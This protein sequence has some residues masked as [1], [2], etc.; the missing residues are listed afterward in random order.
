V[1]E[2]AEKP[3]LAYTHER[4]NVLCNVSKIQELLRYSSAVSVLHLKLLELNAFPYIYFEN[5]IKVVYN[6]ERSSQVHLKGRKKKN[7]LG[8]CC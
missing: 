3:S 1:T 7:N 2:G 5:Q 6:S 4:R 8:F